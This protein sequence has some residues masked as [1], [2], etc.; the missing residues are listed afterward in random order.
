MAKCWLLS[1][2]DTGA[3][4]S[5]MLK[6]VLPFHDVTSKSALVQ[7]IGIEYLEVPVNS[8]AGIR[9]GYRSSQ[10]GHSHV[11]PD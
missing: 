4:Q 11:L 8:L 6:D 1:F 7:G 2:R 5:F 10:G 9:P 3:S